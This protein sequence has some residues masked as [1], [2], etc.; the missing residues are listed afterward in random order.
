MDHGMRACQ[1]DAACR[2]RRSGN[3]RT[4]RVSWL[5]I[6]S[7]GRK[8]LQRCA[9]RN[10]WISLRSYPGYRLRHPYADNCRRLVAW[11]SARPA[12]IASRCRRAVRRHDWSG[13]RSVHGR[14]LGVARARDGLFVRQ[15]WIDS[16]ASAGVFDVFWIDQH[17]GV[18]AGRNRLGGTPIHTLAARW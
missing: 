2:V 4:W 12:I 5:A 6:W 15:S 11:P 9:S 16:R 3:G 10:I 17:S 18:A 1:G 7:L 13:A 8:V 14:R